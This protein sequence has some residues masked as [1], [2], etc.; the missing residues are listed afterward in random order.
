MIL[1]LSSVKR[2]VFLAHISIFYWQ[3]DLIAQNPVRER[4][5][6]PSGYLFSCVISSVLY[7]YYIFEVFQ[8]HCDVYITIFRIITFAVSQK[9][10][11]IFQTFFPFVND[12]CTFVKKKIIP[13]NYY[14]ILACFYGLLFCRC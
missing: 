1:L 13:K 9:H 7:V 5:E 11:Y 4:D 10:R 6:A 8:R 14:C 3:E 12:F 2:K